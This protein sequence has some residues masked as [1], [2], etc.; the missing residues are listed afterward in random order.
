M[1]LGHGV[2]TTSDSM[3]SGTAEGLWM[4]AS[5]VPVTP[6]EIIDLVLEE[7]EADSAPSRYSVFV[8][9]VYHVFLHPDDFERLR[10]TFPFITQEAIKALNERLQFLNRKPA[11]DFFSNKV[12]RTYRKVGDGE[13]RI[14]FYE[15]RDPESDDS[16][17]IVKSMFDEPRATEERVGTAT[18][19]TVRRSNDGSKDATFHGSTTSGETQRSRPN[20]FATLE[21]EDDTGPQRYEMTKP[22][23]RI[24][25]RGKETDGWADVLVAVGAN[26]S[27]QHCE[28]RWDDGKRGFFLRDTSKF[29][30]AVNGTA[31]P[32]DD[33]IK[34]PGK[35]KIRLADTVTLLF[36]A[37]AE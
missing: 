3:K 34:L 2:E 16:P 14:Y 30:T 36:R 28:I 15:N 4:P 7:M 37:E 8:R 22:T 27:K 18:E 25:R 13:W 21:F 29:G 19:R 6:E 26:V 23:V 31:A 33:E 17:L 10:P 12:R 32:K 24:G 20:V 9:S 5:P 35:A 1:P 11:L